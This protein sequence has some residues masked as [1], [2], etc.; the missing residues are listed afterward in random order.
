M[1]HPPKISEVK[2]SFGSEWEYDDGDVLAV[3]STDQ[4]TYCQIHE[5]TSHQSGKGHGR[6]AIQWMKKEYQ[7]VHVNDPGNEVDAPDAL[8]F[9]LK[10]TEEGLISEMI[11]GYSEQIFSAGEWI[12]EKLDPEDYPE[13]LEKLSTNAPRVG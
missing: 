1:Q 13:L 7:H 2:G 10:L 3:I 8:A 4:K 5:F 12:L 9:W 6:E 11:D